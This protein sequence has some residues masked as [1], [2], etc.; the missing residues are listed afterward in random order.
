MSG[1]HLPLN[2]RLSMGK[3]IYWSLK[4][5]RPPRISIASSKNCLMK[6]PQIAHL[7][8]SAI[9]TVAI[10]L[11]ASRPSF[12]HD[13]PD[14]LSRWDF[15]I[16]ALEG[17]TLD[18]RIGPEVTFSAP[19]R[20]ELEAIGQSVRF[21]RGQSGLIA[22]DYRKVADF[23]PKRELTVSIW[24]AIE[25]PQKWGG[26]VGVME[27][28]GD[29]ERGWLVGYDE[30]HFTFALSTTGADDG[31][32][33]MTYL[34]GTTKWEPGRLYHVVAVYDGEL[35]E[36]YV[37]G[38]HEATS[39]EQSG[40]ILYPSAAPYVVGC[41]RD[42]NE[43]YRLEGRIA[44][45]AVYDQAAKSAWV[46]HEFEHQLALAEQE[47]KLAKVGEGFVVHPYLQYATQT[48]ITIMWRTAVPGT[49]TVRWGETSDC[50]QHVTLEGQTE[51]HEVELTGLSAETQ[52][53]YCVETI[54]ED[55]SLVESDVFTFSTAVKRDTPFAFAVLSDTQG[56]PEVSLQ[57]ATMAWAQRPNF[58]LHAGDL[59][60]TGKNPDHWTQHF[61]PGMKPLI[62]R[63]PFYPVLGNHEQNAKHYFDYVSLPDPE[64]YYHF[65]YG[66]ADFF[67]IDSN[68]NI[69]PGS[70]QY[71][72]LETQ[73]AASDAQW[74]FVCHHHPPY[75]SDEN[76]YG[77]L[78][79][80]NKSTR[81]D[82]RVRQLSKLYD[83]YEVDFVWNGH[84]HS[85]ERT[86]PVRNERANSHGTIYMITGGGGGGLETAGPFRPFFQNNVKRGHH[87]CLVAINGNTL[88]LKAFD[89]EG[90]LFDSVSI[91]KKLADQAP[92]PSATQPSASTSN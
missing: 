91:S 70:E 2:P 80:T 25:A 85:Y 48:S 23:L 17:Q 64:Y 21:R 54:C 45:L 72:W 10:I 55:G 59:V 83:K 11:L 53:F 51:L 56:N 5:R 22:K 74:K 71:Q 92:S 1:Y 82:L 3:A 27:D 46:E 38:K 86:W 49:T 19:L 12:S 8:L 87:Y 57:L 36:L 13:G 35:M 62:E 43:D 40:D 61:F 69:D 31:D 75:S 73:L 32:G 66:N 65:R 14:P 15:D 79:K 24:A 77:N 33:R 68:R 78:W 81:G 76:D 18:A 34:R 26:L 4:Y 89:L 6:L 29:T 44:E 63:V 37:N 60:S 88:E 41:Y 58:C 9:A 90:R 52:Y 30:D 28:D 50:A 7:R 39:K 84:I 20:M 67:M 47:A 42:R 16:D